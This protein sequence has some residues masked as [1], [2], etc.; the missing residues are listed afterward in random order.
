MSWLKKTRDTGFVDVSAAVDGYVS[1]RLLIRRKADVVTIV[2]EDLVTTHSGTKTLYILPPGM[3]AFHIERQHWFVPNSSAPTSIG[4][5][6]IGL[7]GHVVAYQ[8]VPGQPMT[9]RV[10]FDTL[11]DWPA[12]GIA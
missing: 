11:Q 8:Q 7:A 10:Q 5:V 3:R 2:F 1:G 6:N 12:G 9:A 4:T